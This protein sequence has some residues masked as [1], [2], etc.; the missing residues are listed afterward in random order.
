MCAQFYSAMLLLGD[1]LLSFSPITFPYQLLTNTY[2]SCKQHIY[3]DMYCESE[4][5]IIHI[6]HI[7]SLKMIKVSKKKKSGHQIRKLNYL[8][9]I[10][11][12]NQSAGKIV[13]IHVWRFWNK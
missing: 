13:I 9:I 3:S 12:D 7:I 6:G 5:G 10:K 11:N 2:K 8:N 4:M 1:Q